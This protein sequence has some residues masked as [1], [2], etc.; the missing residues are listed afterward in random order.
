[1]A[2]WGK[3]DKGIVAGTVVLTNG[4]A[5]VTA[6][7][8]TTL[9]TSVKLGD[10]V[11]LSTANTAPGTAT[12]Y[13]VAGI[14]NSTVI[15]LSSVYGGA[16]AAAATL[17][18]QKS[19]S[20]LPESYVGSAVVNKRDVVGVDVTE[21]GVA[22]NRARGLKTPGWASYVAGTGGRAG[23]KQ[24]ETLVA[25]RSMIAGVASDAEDDPVAADA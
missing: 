24:V 4:S 6:N 2:L 9:G 17:H 7:S 25:M 3:L 5:T 8:S 11:F 16:T 15:T 13:K 10:S 12:R 1:M 22:A 23:R 14:A 19:P 20:S 21:A 18:F